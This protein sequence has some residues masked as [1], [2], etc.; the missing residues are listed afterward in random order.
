MYD[1]GKII[2]GIVIF[3]VLLTFPVWYV[4]ATGEADSVPEPIIITEEKQCIES[5]EYMKEN[6]MAM[7]NEWRDKYVR[8]GVR[9]YVASDGKEYLM[10][11]TG[12]CLGCHPNK[13]EFCNP[14]HDYT[15]VDPYCWDCHTELE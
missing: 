4:A 3:L 13:T 7:L 12:T 15:G 8:D 6:H 9:T 10:S 5:A 11:L 1:A 14:C 2:A